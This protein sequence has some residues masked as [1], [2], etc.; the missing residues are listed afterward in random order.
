VPFFVDE[1]PNRIGRR[2][3]GKPI[4]APAEVP[5]DVPVFL[6][7]PPAAAHAVAARCRQLG[8]NCVLPPISAVQGNLR[9]AIENPAAV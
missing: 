5:H 1:D 3:D 7:L 9:S 6:G 2:C 4:I 8:I